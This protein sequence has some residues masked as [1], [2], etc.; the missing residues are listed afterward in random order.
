MAARIRTSG[1]LVDAAVRISTQYLKF[2]FVGGAATITHVGVLTGLVEMLGVTPMLANL[3]A[4]CVAFC[5]SF[6]GHFFWTFAG[7]HAPSN[8]AL[9]LDRTL[10]RFLAVALFGI[11]LN[12]LAVYVV[13]ET[14]AM[15]YLY[16]IAVMVTVVPVILFSINKYWAFTGLAQE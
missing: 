3:L 6:L 2:G 16:A 10:V 4:F 12:S 9:K 1:P 11:G 5:V 8:G 15:S 7:T 14:L 13:T